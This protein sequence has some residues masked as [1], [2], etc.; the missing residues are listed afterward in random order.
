MSRD[1]ATQPAETVN[2]EAGGYEITA[3]PDLLAACERAID[4]TYEAHPYYGARYADRG[5]RF[6][7]SDSGWLVKVAVEGRDEADQQVAWLSRF[8]AARGMPTVLM[9][10]H[11]GI[12]AAEVER[13]GTHTEV[14]TV[15][16]GVSQQMRADRL[17]VVDEAT[18]QQVEADFDA[19]TKGEPG[20]VERI[21]LL[22]VSAVA[23][24]AR[25]LRRVEESLMEWVGDPERFSEGWVAAARQAL[26]QARAAAVPQR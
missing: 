12:L 14:A 21:G 23:D 2:P 10:E 26:E 6:S 15:L 9:E 22:L 5:R 18:T 1:H 17:S 13:L 19:A 24:E 8:L 7:S 4:A 25:G 3:D 20:R 11:L 16:T